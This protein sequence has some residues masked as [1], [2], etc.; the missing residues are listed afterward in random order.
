WGETLTSAVQGRQLSPVWSGR[1]GPDEGWPG[2][3]AAGASL[4]I[5]AAGWGAGAAGDGGGRT[6]TGRVRSKH[7]WQRGVSRPSSS[8]RSTTP[9]AREQREQASGA[10]P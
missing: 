5:V 8:R 2:D 10:R 1:K 6:G 3:R 7:Q 9:T 4:G